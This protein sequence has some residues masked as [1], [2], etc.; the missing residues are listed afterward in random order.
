M[1]T[2]QVEVTAAIRSCWS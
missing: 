2:T 1:T